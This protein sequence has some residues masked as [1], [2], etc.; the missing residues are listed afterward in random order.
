MSFLLTLKQGINK[1]LFQ[2]PIRDKRAFLYKDVNISIISSN[3]A[4]GI[5]YYDYGL[6][7]KS[8]TINLF[9]ENEDF[10][11]LCEHIDILDRLSL[12]EDKENEDRYPIGILGKSKIHFLHY[13]SFYEANL[14][15]EKR[16]QRID[17]KNICILFVER[18]KLTAL[19]WN[20]FNNLPY[21]KLIITPYRKETNGVVYIPYKELDSLFHFCGFSG[22]RKY[23]KYIGIDMLIN[24]KKD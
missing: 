21:K 24:L 3:C 11:W 2:K 6:E 20:R 16:K 12:R 13:K 9:L 8:P 7:F 5:L 10:I 14:K 18:E 22:K 1:K 15:W 17:Y 23:E 4:G 19:Q